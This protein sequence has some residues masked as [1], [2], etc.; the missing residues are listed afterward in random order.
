MLAPDGAASGGGSKLQLSP[1]TQEAGAG[2]SLRL[3][4]RA[5][6]SLAELLALSSHPRA[7]RAGALGGA[8]GVFS[9]HPLDTLRIRM[10]QPGAPHGA[11]AWLLAT[12]PRQT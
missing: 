9:G 7:S 2:A 4:V 1:G 8:L 10:Q 5:R 3:R 12:R 11:R 6:R